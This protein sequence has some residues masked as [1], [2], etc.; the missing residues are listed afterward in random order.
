MNGRHWIQTGTEEGPG[1]N[2]GVPSSAKPAFFTSLDLAY[3]V[4]SGIEIWIHTSRKVRCKSDRQQPVHR[5][6]D[7]PEGSGR[8]WQFRT[9]TGTDQPSPPP[10]PRDE[11][12]KDSSLDSP[13]PCFISKQATKMAPLAVIQRNFCPAMKNCPQQLGAKVR[14]SSLQ[15]CY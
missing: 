11:P 4:Q 2:L 10:P 9:S 15:T 13:K 5:G 12:W 14:H 6:L 8:R 7:L 1:W 3:A